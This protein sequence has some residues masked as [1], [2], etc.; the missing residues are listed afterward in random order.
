M[1]HAI[2]DNVHFKLGG[3]GDWFG[4]MY[5]LIMSTC[6]FGYRDDLEISWVVLCFN[7]PIWPILRPWSLVS[8]S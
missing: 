3:V 4:I 8:V 2:K 1:L 6:L 7:L 5:M